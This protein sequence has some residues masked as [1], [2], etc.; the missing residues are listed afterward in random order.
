M[1]VKEE[2]G[3]GRGESGGSGGMMNGSFAKFE[4][5]FTHNGDPFAPSDSRNTKVDLTQLVLNCVYTL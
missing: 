4:D 5:S 3:E 2:D 1:F